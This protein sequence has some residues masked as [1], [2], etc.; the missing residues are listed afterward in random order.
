[1]DIKMLRKLTQTFGVSGREG[2]INKV[3]TEFVTGYADEITTDGIDNLIVF[4]AGNGKNKKKIMVSAHKDEIGFMVMAIDDKGFLT[5]RGVG[6]IDVMATYSNKVIFKNG[7]IGIMGLKKGPGEPKQDITD[8]YVDIGATSRKDAEKKVKVG[9]V[10]SYLG[11]LVKLGNGR[12]ASK[13]IDDRIGCYIAIQAL[14]KLD[15]QYNDMYFVF[16]SQEELGLRGATVAS[17]GIKPDIGVAV[18]ITGSYDVPGTSTG[19]MKIG[20]G[21]AIKVMDRSVICDETVVGTM[22]EICSS[23]KIKYQM[24]ILPSGGTDAGAMNISNDGVRT[25]GI[26]IPSRNGHSPV[27]VVDMKDVQACIDLLARF[28]DTEIKV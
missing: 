1:M 22:V 15:S 23:N 26:S 3:I 7:T 13:A 14:M 25:G 28:A 6:G 18:D 9:D 2:E 20:E 10:A 17:R 8:M 4:K 19:N 27:C 11:D 16:S 24:D 21:A 5:V 12:V